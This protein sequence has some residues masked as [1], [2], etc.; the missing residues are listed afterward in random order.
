MN[1]IDLRKIGCEDER[2]IELTQNRVQQQLSV[3][4][5]SDLCILLHRVRQHFPFSNQKAPH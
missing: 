2:W 4:A 1:K 5:I 3:C